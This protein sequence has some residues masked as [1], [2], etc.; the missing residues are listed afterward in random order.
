MWRQHEF[1][2]PDFPYQEAFYTLYCQEASGADR[3][4]NACGN[5]HPED[6]VKAGAEP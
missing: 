5:A 3:N 2:V 6:K 4:V 1:E